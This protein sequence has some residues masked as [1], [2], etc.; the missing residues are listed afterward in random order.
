ME[1][2]K[3][4][5]PK[6]E[7]FHVGFQFEEIIFGSNNEWTKVTMTSFK[8]SYDTKYGVSYPE[9]YIQA[10]YI[11]VKFLDRED[12]ESLG[13]NIY[14]DNQHAYSFEE[15]FYMEFMETPNG[16]VSIYRL[17]LECHYCGHGKRCVFEGRV[18]NISDMKKVME[19]VGIKPKEQAF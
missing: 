11:R 8:D 4:Y 3:Y 1:E 6:I 18:K 19:M 15:E 10:R 12:I 5:T 7:D 2:S 14:D 16:N 13:W 17:S 9:G